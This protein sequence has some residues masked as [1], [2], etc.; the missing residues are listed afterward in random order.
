[1]RMLDGRDG[2]SAAGKLGNQP[3]DQRRLA[4]ILEAGDTDNL[5]HHREYS[6]NIRLASIKS[7][8]RLTLKNGS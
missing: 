4:G 8:G 6:L 1:M 2:E 5:V 3:L 7:G